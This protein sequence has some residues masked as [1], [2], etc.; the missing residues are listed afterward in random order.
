[1]IHQDQQMA[2]GYGAVVIEFVTTVSEFLFQIQF[3]E[4]LLCF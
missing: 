1:M 4:Q 2:G 3:P